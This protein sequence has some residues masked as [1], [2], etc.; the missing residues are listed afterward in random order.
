MD[1]TDYTVGLRLYRRISGVA[2]EI[3]PAPSAA[4]LNQPAGRARVTGTGSLAAG[5]YLARFSLTN[6]SGQVDYA[7]NAPQA[8]IWS[9]V[10]L[11]AFDSRAM[12]PP[13]AYRTRGYPIIAGSNL[14]HD[15]SILDEDAAVNATDWD[16]TL[17]LFTAADGAPVTSNLPTMAWVTQNPARFRLSGL[18]NLPAASYVAR[19][20]LEDLDGAVGFVPNGS[21][22]HLWLVVAIP[23]W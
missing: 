5:S 8:Q 18:E 12:A 16:I 2:T 15:F 22:G 10:R 19:Y 21:A 6:L 1:G 23:T 7:P 4:W 13:L 11:S 3:T 17:E 20:R 9:V 14:P